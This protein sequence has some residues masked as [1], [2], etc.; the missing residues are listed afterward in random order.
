MSAIERRTE[1][2]GQI[3]LCAKVTRLTAMFVGYYGGE[4]LRILL[5][6][7]PLLHLCHKFFRNK[8]IPV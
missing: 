4:T 3:A 1:C 7:A 2:S 6:L 5:D 8:E